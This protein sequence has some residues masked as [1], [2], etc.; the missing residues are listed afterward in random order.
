VLPKGFKAFQ[1]GVHQVLEYLPGYC[2]RV[3]GDLMSELDELKGLDL[4]RGALEGKTR[5]WF[6]R[7][8]WSP[9]RAFFIRFGCQHIAVSMTVYR[10][11][12]ATF[13]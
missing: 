7:C 9:R 10:Q 13:A 11:L 5:T 4:R 1:H 2:N 12:S 8:E 6:L 3:I